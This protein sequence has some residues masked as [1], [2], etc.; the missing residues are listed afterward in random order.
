MGYTPA[1]GHRLHEDGSSYLHSP[2]PISRTNGN[3][4]TITTLPDVMKHLKDEDTSFWHHVLDCAPHP[5][6]SKSSGLHKPYSDKADTPYSY[7]A[8]SD[9]M[10]FDMDEPPSHNG[11]AGRLLSQLHPP[12]PCRSRMIRLQRVHRQLLQRWCTVP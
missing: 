5:H 7:D 10:L 12:S 3:Y 2:A 4:Y 6:R 11:T 1:A 9:H 8:L